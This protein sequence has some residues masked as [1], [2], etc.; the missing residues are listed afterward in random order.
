M[1][2][3]AASDCDATT[4]IGVAVGVPDPWGAQLQDYRC[5]LGDDA[6]G[7]PTHLTLVPPTEVPLE[8]TEQIEKH[9]AQVA[10]MCPPFR[11]HLR[12]TG[13][14]RPVSSVVFVGVAAGIS[15]LEVLASY[16]RSGPLDVGLTFPY[17]P[18]VTIA[19]DVEE[20]ALDR[21][22]EEMADFECEF[23]VD[24]FTLYEHSEQDGWQVWRHFPLTGED[25]PAR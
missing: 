16:A 6:S 12:S 10:S 13:T 4:T 8:R 22:F 5:S 19:H 9:L 1:S 3:P 21:A 25:R 15:C 20:T 14:F 17:H 11:V 7:I 23:V 2:G 24:A 18:H